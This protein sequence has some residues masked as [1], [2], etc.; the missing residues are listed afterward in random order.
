VEKHFTINRAKP[1]LLW[2]FSD[3]SLSLSHTHTH[4]HP[5]SNCPSLSLFLWV[6]FCWRGKK[7]R[8]TSCK[9]ADAALQA[10]LPSCVCVYVCVRE[11]EREYGW[12]LSGFPVLELRKST[13]TIPISDDQ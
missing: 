11:R 13:F 2:P 12:L 4:L 3:L 8:V 6:I 5:H 10:K 1:K 7:E 9:K